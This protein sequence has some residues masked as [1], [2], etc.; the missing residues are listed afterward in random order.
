LQN[1][2]IAGLQ[3]GKLAGTLIA[4]AMIVAPLA[5]DRCGVECEAAGTGQA[6]AAAPTCHH[7]SSAGRR[8]GHAP[9]R[10]GQP[11][12][13]IV[14]TSAGPASK[15][16]SILLFAAVGVARPIIDPQREV[17]AFARES[18]SPPDRSRSLSSSPLRI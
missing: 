16:Q 4:L 14:S 5:A 17:P 3:N 10:C 9:K 15:S 8:I 12:R 18:H 13:A 7:D 1:L 6:R 11:H 2:R